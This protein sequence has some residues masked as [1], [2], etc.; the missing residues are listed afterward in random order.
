MNCIVYNGGLQWGRGGTVLTQLLHNYGMKE[1][2]HRF[3]MK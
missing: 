3:F 1:F 2:Q